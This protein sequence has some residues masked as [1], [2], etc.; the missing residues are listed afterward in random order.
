MLIAQLSDLHIRP[1]GATSNRVIESNSL[2]ERALRALARLR[3]AADVVIVTGDLADCGLPEEYEL[4]K[5]LLA[6]HLPQGVHV[7]PGNHDVREAMVAALRCPRA[8]TGFVDYVVD[9]APVRLVMLDTLVPGASHGALRAE[10][11]RWLDEALADAPAAPTMIALHHPPFATGIAHMDAIAIE[12]PGAFA[13]IVRRH[14]QVERIVCGHCHR[15]IVA[16]VGGATATIAPS[17][18]AAV[19]FDLEPGA[20]SAFAMEPPQFALHRWT[21]E[22]GFVSHNVFVEDYAGPYPFLTCGPATM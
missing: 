8:E 1:R 21:R 11:L 7:I 4:L 18:G 12:N 14:P 6:R 17:T 15:Q 9:L 3:P 22:S 20:P 19:V 2:A 16:R 5:G 13:E 10:Q